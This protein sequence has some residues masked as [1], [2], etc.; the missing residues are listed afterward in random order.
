M[1]TLRRIDG[2]VLAVPETAK[3]V[4]SGTVSAVTTPPGPNTA[5]PGEVMAG[6]VAATARRRVVEVMELCGRVG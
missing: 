5:V 3:P 1:M 2:S 4:S 6:R